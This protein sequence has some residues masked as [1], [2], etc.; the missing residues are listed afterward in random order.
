MFADVPCKA[1]MDSVVFRRNT[2]VQNGAGIAT[3]DGV[4][5][6]ITHSVFE[7]N[8]FSNCT[9][10]KPPAVSRYKSTVLCCFFPSNRI[11]SVF[12]FFCFSRTQLQV[13]G[14]IMIGVEQFQINQQCGVQTQTNLTV[15]HIKN[16]SIIENLA[17][18][19]GG[20]I[21]LESGILDLDVS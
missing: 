6:N 8:G 14:G 12:T 18:G 4:R 9:N 11:W 13:G 17:T 20:G 5:L 3:G 10:S 15:V 21:S 1:N 16:S 2:A 7:A 19:R